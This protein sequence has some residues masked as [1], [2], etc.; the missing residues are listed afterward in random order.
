M[1][2]EMKGFFK[3]KRHGS[4]AV[5]GLSLQAKRAGGKY[6]KFVEGFSTQK[7]IPIFAS[8]KKLSPW[9]FVRK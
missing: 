5:A 4:E 3:S 6:S 2:V 8:V 1:L 9:I 7:I